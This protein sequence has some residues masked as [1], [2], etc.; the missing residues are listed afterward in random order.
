MKQPGLNRII[1]CAAVLCMGLSGAVVAQNDAPAWF[2]QLREQ[3]GDEVMSKS[4]DQLSGEDLFNIYRA[5]KGI[6]GADDGVF[7]IIAANPEKIKPVVKLKLS[8]AATPDRE[9]IAAREIVY[10]FFRGDDDFQD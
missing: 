4:A 6:P 8:D 9:K 7:P 2:S 10:I 5:T 1:Y 3:L